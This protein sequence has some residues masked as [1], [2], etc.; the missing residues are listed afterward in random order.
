MSVRIL[1]YLT[2]IIYIYFFLVLFG[3][4]ILSFL[5]LYVHIKIIKITWL[6]DYLSFWFDIVTYPI[7]YIPFLII[8]ISIVS[9][10]LLLK[11]NKVI[12]KNRGNYIIF[13]IVNLLIGSIMLYYLVQLWNLPR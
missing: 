8:A 4:R 11:S 1:S 2:G 6:I 9:L 13:F 12:Q 7:E 5:V 10:F 3:Y